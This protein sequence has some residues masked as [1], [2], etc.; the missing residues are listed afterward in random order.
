MPKPKVYISRGVIPAVLS[1]LGEVCETRSWA[2]AGR[3]PDE[4]LAKEAE[5]RTK[6]LLSVNGKR[7][8]DAFHIELGKLMWDEPGDVTDVQSIGAAIQ[9]MLLAAQE[10]AQGYNHQQIDPEHMLL[11]LLQQEDG[12][13]PEIVENIGATAQPAGGPRTGGATLSDNMRTQLEGELAHSGFVEDRDAY[14]SLVCRS[15][16]VLST[17]ILLLVKSTC[18]H[19]SPRISPSLIPVLT[20]MMMMERSVGEADAKSLCSSSSVRNRSLRLSF[21]G[22]NLILGTV[23]FSR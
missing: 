23:S 3:C 16:F 19:L 12:V 20:A 9:N 10:L 11:A 6:R 18:S 22:K 2:G 4:V 8:P 13:V 17:L 15:D 1:R 7:S 21:S 5:E 14:L